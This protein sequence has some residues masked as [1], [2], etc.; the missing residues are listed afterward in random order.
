MKYFIQ[1]LQDDEGLQ[2]T[3]GV[4]ARD[5]VDGILASMGYAPLPVVVDQ[6]RRK[7]AGSLESLKIHYQIG[8]I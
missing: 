6:N 3:A 2:K 7:E 1:E 8:R 5:D 4:K